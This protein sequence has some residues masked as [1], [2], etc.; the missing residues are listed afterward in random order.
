VSL[1]EVAEPVTRAWREYME[2][3]TDQEAA[4]VLEYTST[5]GLRFR[6]S[7]DD[8]LTQLFGHSLY[9]RGQIAQL[10]RS[11]GAQPPITD[12]VFWAR[13]PLD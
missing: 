9:H 2:G 8:V 5:E 11:G 7:V 10:L 4:R 6:N 13:A 3:L 12:F 1:R